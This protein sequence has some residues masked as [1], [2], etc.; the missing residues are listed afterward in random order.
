MYILTMFICYMTD[1][2]VLSSQECNA[3]CEK[4]NCVMYSGQ[5]AR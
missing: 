2:C 4:C 1:V 3:Y 5:L